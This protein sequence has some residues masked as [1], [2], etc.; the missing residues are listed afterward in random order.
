MKNQARWYWLTTDHLTT[1]RSALPLLL[2]AASFCLLGWRTF[3]SQWDFWVY[4]DAANAILKGANPYDPASFVSLMERRS[5]F[6]FT[7]P[8]LTLIFFLPLAVLPAGLAAVVWLVLKGTV[9]VLALESLWR[10][11]QIR[12]AVDWRHLWLLLFGFNSALL[13]DL[14]AGN[15]AVPLFAVLALSL[16]W[17][18]HGKYH[19]FA[20]SIAL[21]AQFKLFPVVFLALLLVVRPLPVRA[22]ITGCVAF[23]VLV[24]LNMLFPADYFQS[25][26]AA[27]G[28]RVLEG[29]IVEP[30]LFAFSHG[31]IGVLNSITS[32]GVQISSFV[33]RLFFAVCAIAIV[34]VSVPA[35]IRDE[36]PVALRVLFVMTI[37]VL[38]LPRIKSYTYVIMLMPAFY[39]LQED[40]GLSAFLL[41]LLLP[42]VAQ[43][44]MPTLDIT[45]SPQF[46][47][48][49]KLLRLAYE[50]LPLMQALAVWL[51]LRRKLLRV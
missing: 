25:F 24:C 35:L 27:A 39:L 31:L 9:F 43:A 51:M 46:G 15:L 32:A 45:G 41:F 5:S 36:K 7:Y 22:M 37:L 10:S 19:W 47:P 13:W 23:L 29:S 4:Y 14:A 8:P 18:L 17:L 50:Y 16:S 12:G 33:A 44:G 2:L 49:K 42:F 34:A 1:V 20:L 48:V 28:T 21:I 6:D 11:L 40:D 26:L 3:D 38:L 30:S